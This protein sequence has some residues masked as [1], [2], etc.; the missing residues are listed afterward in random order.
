MAD[1]LV[2]NISDLTNPAGGPRAVTIGA[3]KIWPGRSS[4]VSASDITPVVRELIGTHI[5]LGHLSSDYRPKR[6]VSQSPMS[7]DEFKAH[8][9]KLPLSQLHVLADAVSPPLSHRPNP[10]RMIHSLLRAYRDPNT[11]DPATF[12]FTRRWV[13]LGSDTYVLAE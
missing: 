6:V 3:T 2:N 7:E 5:E 13:K 10:P 8:L 9:E 1:V 12:F 4:L 11:L